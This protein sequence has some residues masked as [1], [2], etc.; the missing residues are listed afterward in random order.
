M[1]VR[2]CG[3]KRA[4]AVIHHGG[5]E[6][7]ETDPLPHAFAPEFGEG[8]VIRHAAMLDKRHDGLDDEP[9]SVPPAVVFGQTVLHSAKAAMVVHAQE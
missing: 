1:D 5:A 4:R 7:F 9:A 8:R 6:L 3:R 2:P